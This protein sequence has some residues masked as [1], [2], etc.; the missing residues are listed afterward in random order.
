VSSANGLGPVEIDT[1]NGLEAEGDGNL[2]TINGKVYTR[3]LGTHAPSNISYYLGGGCSRLTVDVGIDDE[4]TEGGIASFAILADG[5]V[6]AESGVLT[7]TDPAL[8]LTADVTGATQMELVV[9]S[10][11]APLG[12]H[13]DWAMPS[14]VCGGSDAPSTIEQT[15][16]SFEGGSEDFTI[17]NVAAGGTVAPSPL[18]ASDGAGGLEVT[19]PTDGNWFGKRLPAP[20]DLSAFSTLRYDVKTGAIGTSGEFAVEVGPGAAWCQGNTWTWTNANASRTIERT[21]AELAC[22]PGVTMDPS[23]ILGIWV[24][25][26]DGTFQIDNVR[27]E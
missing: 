17:A 18:F 8:T 14:I 12:D 24:F 25:L 20:T 16:F 4:V 1:S 15:L 5:V 22:P 26:K 7:A 13:A 3:G 6:V 2:I 23:Q 10:G 19:S 11:D 27:V 9:S 21:F